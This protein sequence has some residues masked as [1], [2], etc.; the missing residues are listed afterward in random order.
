MPV[1]DFLAGGQADAGSRIFVAMQAFEDAEN[2]RLIFRRNS[3]A[4]VFHGKNPLVRP[5]LGA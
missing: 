3:D 2:L 1:H 5:L 4:V